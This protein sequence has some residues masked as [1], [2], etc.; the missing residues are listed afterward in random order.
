LGIWNN[1]FLQVKDLSW[2]LEWN[3]VRP[4]TYGHGVGGNIS[5]NYTNYYQPLTDPFAANFN[6]FISMFNY[7]NA[8]WYG[9]LENVYTIRGENP[10]LPYNNGEDLWGGENGVPTF[11]SKTMQGIKTK[12]SFNQLTLGYLINPANR[13]GVEA[14]VAYRSRKSSIVNQSEFYFSFGIKTSLYNLYHDF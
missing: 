2:R 8:R 13:L 3:G 6:E 12:Y 9:V 4:Y 1:N 11:G 14:N 5:L 7:I 10:G